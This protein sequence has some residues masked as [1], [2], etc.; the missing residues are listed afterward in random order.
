VIVD[1]AVVGIAV[2][3]LGGVDIV[4]VEEDWIEKAD[5]DEDDDD[6]AVAVE[7]APLSVLCTLVDI[8]ALLG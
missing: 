4:D 7:V 8:C 5:D 1:D 3:V 6:D 2:V